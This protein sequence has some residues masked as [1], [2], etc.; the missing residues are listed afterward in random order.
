MLAKVAGKCVETLVGDELVVMNI[1]SGNFYSL[2]TTARD[3]WHL[4]GTVA[5][6]QAVVAALM[7]IYEAPEAVIRADVSALIAKL[8]S[9]ELVT[10]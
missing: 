5:D 7:Q 1:D 3:A 8:K 9:A 6:A 10:D 2:K 4:I